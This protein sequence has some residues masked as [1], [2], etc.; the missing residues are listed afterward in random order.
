MSRTSIP[1]DSAT[2]DRLSD[3]KRED[4]TWDEFLIRITSDEQPIEFGAWSDDEADE[5][6]QRLRE[7]RERPE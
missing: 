1:I 3:L 6:M 5:A 7:G 2:K 4:E